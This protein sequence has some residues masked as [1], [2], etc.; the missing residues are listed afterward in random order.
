MGIE[1]EYWDDIKMLIKPCSD[2]MVDKI[3]AQIPLVNFDDPNKR[4]KIYGA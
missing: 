1:N 3:N 2:F 4:I